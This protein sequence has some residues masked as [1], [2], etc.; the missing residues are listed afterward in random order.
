MTSPERKPVTSLKRERIRAENAKNNKAVSD[1]KHERAQAK[2]ETGQKAVLQACN[3][4]TA[5]VSAFNAQL[6]GIRLVM[7]KILKRLPE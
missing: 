3:K 1:L 4:L 2:K 7:N 6:N 5:Q